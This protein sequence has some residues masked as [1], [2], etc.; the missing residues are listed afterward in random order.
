M[1]TV[2]RNPAAEISYRRCLE[3]VDGFAEAYE[4]FASRLAAKPNRGR[5][6]VG[7]RREYRLSSKDGPSVWATYTF[8]DAEVLLFTLEA[9][10]GD[11]RQRANDDGVGRRRCA[12]P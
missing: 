4:E 9:S 2:A 1:R 3:T 7:G 12:Q 11:F 10:V 5:R 8:N 6:V